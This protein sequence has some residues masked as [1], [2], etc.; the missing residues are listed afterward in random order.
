M[1]LWFSANEVDVGGISVVV[2]T[3]S[4]RVGGAVGSRERMRVEAEGF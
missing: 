1:K 2:P 4:E 3:A